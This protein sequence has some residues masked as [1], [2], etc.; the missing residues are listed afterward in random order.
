MAM[1]IYL[2]NRKRTRRV[3]SF[4][5]QRD[6]LGPGPRPKA[7][8]CERGV[9]GMV[10]ISSTSLGR[11]RRSPSRTRRQPNQESTELRQ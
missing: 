2:G 6:F 5:A 3:C 10:L 11:F 4:S 1:A 7:K 8:E 9:A